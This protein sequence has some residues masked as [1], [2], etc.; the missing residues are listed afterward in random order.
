MTDGTNTIDFALDQ[1]Y[2]LAFKFNELD[3][4]GRTYDVSISAGS[5]A[6]GGGAHVGKIDGSV[7][8]KPERDMG[9]D[10]PNKNKRQLWYSDGTRL[11]W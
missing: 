3:D 7:G 5:A 8:W 4:A 10:E 9:Q 1:T 6:D 2:Q 11:Y